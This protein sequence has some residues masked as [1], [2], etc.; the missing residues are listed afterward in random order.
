M[1]FLLS[2][3]IT[4]RLPGHLFSRLYSHAHKHAGVHIFACMIPAV[5]ILM[6]SPVRPAHARDVNDEHIVVFGQRPPVPATALRKTVIE[7]G[8][9]RARGYRDVNE[10]LSDVPGLSVMTSGGRNGQ[11]SVFM[12]GAESDHVLVIIDGVRVSDPA[13]GNRAAFESLRP[14]NLERVVVVRGPQGARYG[15]RAI[16]GVILIE[17]KHG[18]TVP[19]ATARIESGLDN[20]A[21]GH[22]G[23]SG[24]HR[25][26]GIW[27]YFI[28][29]DYRRSDGDSVT[30]SRLRDGVE[31][32]DDGWRNLNVNGRVSWDIDDIGRLVFAFGETDSRSEYD[33]GT[34]PFDLPGYYSDSD[35]HRLSMT[36]EGGFIGFARPFA[37]VSRYQRLRYEVAPGTRGRYRGERVRYELGSE[38]LLGDK[39]SYSI[40]YENE[41]ETV[42]TSSFFGDLYGTMRSESIYTYGEYDWSDNTV[43]SAAWR[44]EDVE[45]YGRENSIQFGVSHQ[46]PEWGAGFRV[47]YATAFKAPNEDERIGFAG[48]PDLKAEKSRGWDVSVDKAA[49]QCNMGITYFRL[50]TRDLIEYNFATMLLENIGRARSEGAE[51]YLGCDITDSLNARLD[52]TVTRA[53]DDEHRRLLRRPLRQSGINVDWKAT[54]DWHLS[55]RM[56]YTGPRADIA[57]D[58]FARISKG[59]YTLTH[60]NIRRQLTDDIEGYLRVGN[61]FDKKY[62]AVDGYAGERF[63]L[64][65]GLTAEL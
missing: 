49:G 4:N 32:D 19:R 11:T 54:P 50:N 65:F 53:T 61:L 15:S 42:S 35:E 33:A 52:W 27:S 39:V 26:R 40:A 16:G 5:V 12:R 30:A 17:T 44:H 25:A 36:Y 51:S 55:L 31:G 38:F 8:Q 29:A 37:R 63:G 41:L 9:I 47:N 60:L 20:E 6:V 46:V 62:E 59:G 58:T 14:E 7:A 48:N 10:L 34:A 56:N 57:R 13:A 1:F 28:G 43:L 64:H 3:S 18:T 2:N 21:A 45:S 22:L 24:T 23:F